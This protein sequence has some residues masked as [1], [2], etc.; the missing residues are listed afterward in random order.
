MENVKEKLARYA[1]KVLYGY[2]IPGFFKGEYD[3]FLELDIEDYIKR[4][5]EGDTTVFDD[6][7]IDLFLGRITIPSGWKNSIDEAKDMLNKLQGL[8]TE[9]KNINLNTDNI[10]FEFN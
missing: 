4:Y 1:D 3:F 6:D 7:I 5:N 9:N 2:T 10:T 8:Y